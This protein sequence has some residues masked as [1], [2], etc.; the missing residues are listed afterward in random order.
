MAIQNAHGNICLAMIGVPET[1]KPNDA[2]MKPT[3]NPTTAKTKSRTN[4]NLWFIFLGPVIHCAIIDLEC[5]A[6]LAHSKKYFFDRL[7]KDYG[8]SES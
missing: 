1:A 4:E 6:C 2:K 3:G 8:K 5:I 7:I